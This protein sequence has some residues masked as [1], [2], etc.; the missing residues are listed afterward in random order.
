M[1]IASK[2]VELHG[3]TI[4]AESAGRGQGATFTVRLPAFREAA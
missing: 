4:A 1:S 2:L 3:G